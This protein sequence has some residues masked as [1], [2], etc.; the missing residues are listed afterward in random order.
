M[1]GL[2]ELSIV[3]H[4]KAS[5]KKPSLPKKVYISRNGL[6]NFLCGDPE[7]CPLLLHKKM[8]ICYERRSCFKIFTAQLAYEMRLLTL[9]KEPSD[10][11]E[12]NPFSISIGN[13]HCNGYLISVELSYNFMAQAKL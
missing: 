9:R 13:L 8:L 3:P 7:S 12:A 1:E 5:T 6:A 10:V 11:S 2:Q 4:T